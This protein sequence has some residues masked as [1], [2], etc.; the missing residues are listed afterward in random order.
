MATPPHTRPSQITVLAEFDQIVMTEDQLRVL[1][2]FNPSLVKEGEQV[3]LPNLAKGVNPAKARSDALLQHLRNT[4]TNFNISFPVNDF[5]LSHMHF[6]HERK[7]IYCFIPKVACTSWKRIWMKITGL[8]KPDKDLS[9]IDRYVIHTSIPSLTSQK[10][11]LPDIM[12]NYKKF[13]FIRHP[14]SRVLSAFRDKIEHEDPKSGYNFHRE[15]GKKIQ[16]KYSNELLK[17]ASNNTSLNST[18]A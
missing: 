18:H 5:M 4:C 7:A 16:K 10:D 14:F 17:T 12:A 15:I 13:L 11:K 8:V 2:A 9:E 6:D 3:Q 1:R